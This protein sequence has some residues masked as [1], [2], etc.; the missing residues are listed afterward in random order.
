VPNALDLKVIAEWIDCSIDQL[1][2]LNPELRR[3]TTPI[4]DHEL[5][6]PFGTA[7]TVRTKLATDDPQ[8]VHFT[9]HTVRRGETVAGIARKYRLSQAELRQANDL[10]RRARIRT[11]QQLM[12]PQRT[13]SA[14]PSKP[15]ETP[16]RSAA[17]GG[18]GAL[19]YRVQR[20]D[21]LFSIARQF[22]TTVSLL[23]RLNG[24]RTDRIAIGARLT[25][26]R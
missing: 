6:V 11:N 2:E 3:T 10:S 22:D 19:S 20:G 24:L 21:T 1:R 4:G 16:V 13:A 15:A 17:A 12:I 25:V 8:Y 9:F 14:L 26:R 7:A 23:K 5:K 18:A